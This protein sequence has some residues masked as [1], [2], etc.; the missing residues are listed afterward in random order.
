M[1]NAEVE[2]LK[3]RLDGMERES[4]R[5][6]VFAGVAFGLLGASLL[7]GATTLSRPTD[8]VRTKRLTVVDNDGRSRAV[9]GTLIGVRYRFTVPIYGGGADGAGVGIG[10]A[11]GGLT[12][13]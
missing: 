7:M 1:N 2:A 6:R 4:R 12:V 11:I 9:L 13:T 10:R 3:R 8:E 5:W